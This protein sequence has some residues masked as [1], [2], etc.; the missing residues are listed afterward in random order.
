[1]G[2]LAHIY[3][4]T[5]GDHQ[6][7][8]I[9]KLKLPVTPFPDLQMLQWILIQ[10]TREEVLDHKTLT[11]ITIKETRIEEAMVD[12]DMDMDIIHVG[13]RNGTNTEASTTCNLRGVFAEG[14]LYDLLYHICLLHK[15]M[16]ICA[17]F[18]TL[19]CTLVSFFYWSNLNFSFHF[20]ILLA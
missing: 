18:P 4:Q 6:Q 16:C 12:M 17:L 14:D 7:S 15:C 10:M 1:M 19:S 3:H 8:R 5:E 11:S 20:L 9:P 2:I 13:I